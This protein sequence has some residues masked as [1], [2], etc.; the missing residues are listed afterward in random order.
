VAHTVWYQAHM[1]YMQ[2]LVPRQAVQIKGQLNACAIRKGTAP[3]GTT[4]CTSSRAVLQ[5]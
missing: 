2:A 1:Q 5:N 3:S 4:S